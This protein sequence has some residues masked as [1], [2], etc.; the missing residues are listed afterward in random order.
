MFPER[1]IDGYHHF[2]EGRFAAERT[3]YEMLAD[4][5]QKP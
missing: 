2:I 1:L 3:R 4:K 5:G